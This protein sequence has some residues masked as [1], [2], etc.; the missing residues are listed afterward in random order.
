MARCIV[1]DMENA[2]AYFKVL[3]LLLFQRSRKSIKILTK[4]AEA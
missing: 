3:P 1:K 2:V 4:A